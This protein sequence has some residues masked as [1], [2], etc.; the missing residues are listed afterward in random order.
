MFQHQ[1]IL[2]IL[3]ILLIFLSHNIEFEKKLN[4]KTILE[5]PQIKKTIKNITLIDEVIR[6]FSDIS[7]LS[8]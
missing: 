6:I 1:Y 4:H 7:L 3:I 8:A 2:F 5:E